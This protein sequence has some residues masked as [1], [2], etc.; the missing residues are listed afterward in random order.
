MGEGIFTY[1]DMFANQ[2][3]EYGWVV[4]ALIVMIF[5]WRFLN[6]SADR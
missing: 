3:T 6:M 5:F 4:I 1:H 2:G